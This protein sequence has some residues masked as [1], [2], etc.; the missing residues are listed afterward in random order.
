[1]PFPGEEA[2][3][4]PPSVAVAAVPPPAAAA[5]KPIDAQAFEKEVSE[6]LRVISVPV[7][8][9]G[10]DGRVSFLSSD[11]KT[12]L[13]LDDPRP[14]AEQIEKKLGRSPLSKERVDAIT[15][16]GG[17]RVQYSIHPLSS[18]G[19]AVTLRREQ[20]APDPTSETSVGY[21]T[22]TVV[23]PLRALQ[24]ALRAASAARSGDP[25]LDDAAATIDQIFSSIELSP[26]SQGDGAKEAEPAAPAKEILERVGDRFRRLAELKK[27]KLQVDAPGD[28]ALEV[29]SHER[30]Q[31]A[32]AALMENSL[33]YVP[34]GG[35]IVLGLRTL[36]SKGKKQL[37]FF[38][39]DNG[40]LV[41]AESRELIF[42]SDY[43]W[44]STGDRG[45]RGLND[46]RRVSVALGGQVWVEA[47]GGKTCTFFLRI[48]ARA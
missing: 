33:H 8:M 11:A 44:K 16:V 38:V 25:V 5:A 12:R 10:S 15:E 47:K 17:A 18:G 20:Q 24:D 36:E 35:Q 31:N 27:V 46:V 3:A 45:G 13:A 23:A 7:V 22:E 2:Q 48:P 1:V 28:M 37:L 21:L 19:T 6:L 39:M 30:V 40:P 42:N 32:L 43:V 9:F 29:P 4:A 26:L 14:T 41:P 34:A